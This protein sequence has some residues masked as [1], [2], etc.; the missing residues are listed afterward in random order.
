MTQAKHYQHGTNVSRPELQKF[1]GA[2][3]G[4]EGGFFVT[5]SDFTSGARAYAAQFGDRL[6][7]VSGA[8]LQQM[9][10]EQ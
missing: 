3:I 9:S 5:S 4:Y 1:V 10:E 8:E 2:M 6:V 7:L